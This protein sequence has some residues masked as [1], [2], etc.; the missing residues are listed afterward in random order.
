[1]WEPLYCMPVLYAP[2]C[3]YALSDRE[4]HTV[5]AWPPTR[6][7]C[8]Q[9]RSRY[10]TSDAVRGG[11]QSEGVYSTGL[12]LELDVLRTDRRGKPSTVDG[13]PPLTTVLMRV[14]SHSSWMSSGQLDVR[15]RIQYR[16][17][18][19]LHSSWMSSGQLEVLWELYAPA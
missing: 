11:I 8:P 5:Q 2:L 10:R 16:F 3:L 17:P 6:A 7:G 15:P 9:D 13:M 12:A 18:L 14:A 4:G 19:R 1:M